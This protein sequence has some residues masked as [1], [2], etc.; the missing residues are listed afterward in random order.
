MRDGAEREV[1][2]STQEAYADFIFTERS[3][4]YVLQ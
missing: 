4:S 1:G 2:V 3:M